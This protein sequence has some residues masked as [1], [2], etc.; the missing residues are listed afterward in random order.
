MTARTPVKTPTQVSRNIPVPIRTAHSSAPYEAMAISQQTHIDD[1]VQKNRTLDHVAKKLKDELLAE[2]ARS[3]E[4]AKAI[5]AQWQTEGAE[6]REG[7]ES[8]QANHRIAHLRTIV[9]LERERLAV[10][11]EKDVTRLESM[12]RLQRDFRIISFQARESDLER[13]IEQLEETIEDVRAQGE[14]D[15]SALITQ[16]QQVTEKLK[17][18]CAELAEELAQTSRELEKVQDHRD[19]VEVRID[20]DISSSQ[21]LTFFC[22]RR[23]T[24]NYAKN[25]LP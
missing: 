9:E 25:M 13:Q 22:N 10:V 20:N 7:C 11:K 24:L 5:K 8:L 1:L 15:T 12:A 19:K 6:W 3:K 23:N 14:E 18:Q 17:L 16:H 4:A 2:Q 21:F